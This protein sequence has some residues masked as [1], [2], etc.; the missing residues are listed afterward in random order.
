MKLPET[1]IDEY[2]VKHFIKNNWGYILEMIEDSIED[3]GEFGEQIIDEL[4]KYDLNYISLREK[5]DK[6]DD[7]E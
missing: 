5:E 4:R 1:H 6:E 7:E 3:W 2:F